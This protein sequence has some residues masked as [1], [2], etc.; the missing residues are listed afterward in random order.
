MAEL[1]AVSKTPLPTKI[2]LG[3]R[4]Q[5]IWFTASFA[6]YVFPWR[7]FL[8]SSSADKSRA[9]VDWVGEDDLF[10]HKS[11]EIRLKCRL[12]DTRSTEIGIKGA[13][14]QTDRQAYRHK[15]ENHKISIYDANKGK[16]DTKS[17]QK[18]EENINLHLD[19]KFQPVIRDNPTKFVKLKQNAWTTSERRSFENFN[20]HVIKWSN[21]IGCTC[22]DV[23][24][25]GIS[26]T[27]RAF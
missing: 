24:H 3:Q 18:D 25:P 22:D 6:F 16:K 8:R 10:V 27:S 12:I 5:I 26:V 14:R 15:G 23:T 21:G 19:N 4:F 2:F 9:E 11:I 17:I 7:H 13:T 20:E 1:T